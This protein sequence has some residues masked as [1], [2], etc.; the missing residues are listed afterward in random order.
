[1]QETQKRELSFGRLSFRHDRTQSFHIG[2]TAAMTTCIRSSPYQ[3]LQQSV[4]DRGGAYKAAP[5]SENLQAVDGCQGEGVHQLSFLL[6]TLGN[7]LFMVIDGE[8]EA[9]S[10][11][12]ATATLSMCLSLLLHAHPHP[13]ARKEKENQ[14]GRENRSASVRR[15]Q[16]RAVR[17]KYDQKKFYRL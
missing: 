1:M 9:V 14:F 2:L 13:M 12:V 4:V 11:G 6:S 7:W 5:L 15:G 10:S 3:V 16:E 17:Y 8:G